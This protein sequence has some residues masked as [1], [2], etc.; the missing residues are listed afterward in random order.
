MS[1]ITRRD[2]FKGMAILGG[3]IVL[4][5]TLSS[6]KG[7]D[8]TEDS[9]LIYLEEQPDGTF[10]MKMDSGYVYTG[11]TDTLDVY[12]SEYDSL[13]GRTNRRYD[14]KKAMLL[15]HGSIR[16]DLLEI[17]DI[18]VDANHYNDTK[19]GIIHDGNGYRFFVFDYHFKDYPNKEGSTFCYKEQTM[20]PVPNTECILLESD[21]K[22]FLDPAL[23]SSFDLPDRTNE[24]NALTAQTKMS[25]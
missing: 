20:G 1:N 13:Q 19:K 24:I 9:N 5:G 23:A 22:V 7:L 15:D 2:F 25:R 12:A 11:A 14:K 21:T 17:N 6:C 8:N 16:D 3:G 4:S 10:L 18:L